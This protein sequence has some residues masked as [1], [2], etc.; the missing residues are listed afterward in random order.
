MWGKIMP[1]SALLTLSQITKPPCR[2]GCGETPTKG[3]WMRGHWLRSNGGL[4]LH[5]PESIPRI[6]RPGSYISPTA[7]WLPQ[8]ERALMLAVLEDAIEHRRR[9]THPRCHQCRRDQGWALDTAET[10]LYAFETIC[11]SIG[12]EAERIRPL[13]VTTG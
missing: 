9:C 13:F 11:N 8:P 5:L 7:A 1:A 6:D 12:F 10:F 4:G 2:C 3:Q